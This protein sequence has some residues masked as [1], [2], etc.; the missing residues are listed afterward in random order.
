MLS[1]KLSTDSCITQL[2]GKILAANYPTFPAENENSTKGKTNVS[3]K[4][5]LYWI[6]EFLLVAQRSK[7]LVSF[8]EGKVQQGKSGYHLLL[9]VHSSLP[10]AA[11]G[12]RS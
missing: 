6:K 3:R 12:D 11:T 5:Q 10:Q 1:E 4:P 7:K 9:S 8:E 2:Q